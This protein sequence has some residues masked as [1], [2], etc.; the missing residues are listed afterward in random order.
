M[1]VPDGEAA[2]QRVEKQYDSLLDPDNERELLEL[3]AGQLSAL[4][5]QGL[6][7]P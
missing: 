6:P 2:W 3:L 1:N 4:G 7:Q 5:S